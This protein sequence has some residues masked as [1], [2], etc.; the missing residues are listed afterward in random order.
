LQGLVDFTEHVVVG[1][2]HAAGDGEAVGEREDD[3]LRA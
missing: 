3:S 1:K 2:K